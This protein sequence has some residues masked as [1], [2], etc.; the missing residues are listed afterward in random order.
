MTK[1]NKE[2]ATIIAIFHVNL[3]MN[4]VYK[5]MLSGHSDNPCFAEIY[6][7]PTNFQPN[8]FFSILLK[9]W[10]ITKKTGLHTWQVPGPRLIDQL[11]YSVLNERENH[12]YTCMK[13]NS[14][15]DTAGVSWNNAP[16]GVNITELF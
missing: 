3:H 11:F 4:E 7:N 6:R 2:A 14:L 16:P 9:E 13:G 10:K 1:K 5:S 15:T 8:W 12:P